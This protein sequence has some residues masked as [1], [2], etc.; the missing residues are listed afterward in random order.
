MGSPTNQVREW[1]IPHFQLSLTTQQDRAGREAPEISHAAMPEVLPHPAACNPAQ[2]IPRSLMVAG[3]PAVSLNSPTRRR[4]PPMKM[5]MLRPARVKWRFQAMAR[6]HPMA[7]RG[8]DAL[9]SKHPHWHKP[10]LWY[11]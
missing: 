11:A 7:K 9:K 2:P 4:M 10:S 6:W 8:K 1:T 5:G 3:N